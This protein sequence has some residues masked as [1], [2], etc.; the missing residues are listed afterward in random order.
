MLASSHRTIAASSN[1]HRFRRVGAF[2]AALLLCLFAHRDASA[3]TPGD[4]VSALSLEVPLA[5]PIVFD[6]SCDATPAFCSSGVQGVSVTRDG[7]PVDGQ[8]GELRLP[9][10]VRFAWTPTAPLVDGASYDV[11]VRIP[12]PEPERLSVTASAEVHWETPTVRELE[13]QLKPRWNP[14]ANSNEPQ[15]GLYCC[16]RPPFNSV[17]VGEEERMMPVIE[18]VPTENISP[19]LYVRMSWREPDAFPPVLPVFGHTT[20]WQRAAFE[21]PTATFQYQMPQYCVYLEV[22]DLGSGR[23]TGQ[24]R[25]HEPDPA[26]G[27]WTVRPT[28]EAPGLLAC[29]D[30]PPTGVACNESGCDSVP[31]SPRVHDLWCDHAA[32]FCTIDPSGKLPLCQARPKHCDAA[33]DPQPTEPLDDDQCA[34]V[35]FT[36][37]TVPTLIAMLTLVLAARGRRR[38]R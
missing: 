5:G 4:G 37:S 14:V 32:A 36:P 2:V 8:L 26:A 6:L 25:C 15:G 13:T 27:Y 29:L 33:P 10:S 19:A 21:S 9:G 20:P 11:E 35:R 3:S 12:R 38:T 16:M 31:A 7:V 18:H 1:A 22:Y 28:E 24:T 23:L 34:L 30:G 17:C